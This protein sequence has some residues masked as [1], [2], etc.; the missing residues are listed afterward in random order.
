[1]IWTVP[2]LFDRLGH[3]RIARELGRGL[4]TVTAAV[5]ARE[6]PAQWYPTIWRLCREDKLRISQSQLALLCS[7]PNLGDAAALGG[8]LRG[9]EAPPPRVMSRGE[10]RRYRQETL[11]NAG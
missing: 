1:M 6:I 7:F 3:E 11:I 8:S 4:S 10:R 2:I 5:T 9:I